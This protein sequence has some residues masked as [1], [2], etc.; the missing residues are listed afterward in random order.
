MLRAGGR[1]ERAA[2][3]AVTRELPFAGA[4]G[5]V[6]GAKSGTT[7]HDVDMRD[8]SLERLAVRVTQ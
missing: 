7:T 8:L 1:N 2:I 3:G 6:G 4:A 5:A